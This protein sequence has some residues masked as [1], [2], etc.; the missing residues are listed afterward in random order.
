MYKHIQTQ[1]LNGVECG[2]NV[3]GE[4]TIT[5]R[6]NLTQ[7]TNE[8]KKE[9]GRK[10]SQRPFELS[11]AVFNEK[12]MEN[13]IVFLVSVLLSHPFVFFVSNRNSCDTYEQNQNKKRQKI[14]LI[15]HDSYRFRL[16]RYTNSIFDGH[17]IERCSLTPN[18]I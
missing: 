9:Y 12:I 14:S 13:N 2:S 8:H 6:E 1:T 11:G 18:S 17:F 7:R 4:K 16:F 10:Y 15:A 5:I 3:R